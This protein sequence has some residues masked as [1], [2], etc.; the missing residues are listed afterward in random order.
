MPPDVGRDVVPDVAHE[1]VVL[2]AG[3]TLRFPV[4]APTVRAALDLLLRDLEFGFKLTEVRAG[5][6][7][8][9]LV[10]RPEDHRASCVE[11]NLVGFALV[12]GE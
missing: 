8:L 1:Q 2:L 9:E 10:F 6:H 4:Q 7:K 11:V 12:I 5:V 3:V